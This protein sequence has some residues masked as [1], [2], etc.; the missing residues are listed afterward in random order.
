M[1][2]RSSVHFFFPFPSLV[3]SAAFKK[4]EACVVLID[5]FDFP[6]PSSLLIALVRAERE[7]GRIPSFFP[8]P[9]RATLGDRGV[10]IRPP[11]RFFLS[12]PLPSSIA[13][14]GIRQTS[15]RIPPFPFGTVQI[16]SKLCETGSS[17][18]SPPGVVLSHGRLLRWSFLSH[19]RR[20]R[21]LF[22]RSAPSNLFLPPCLKPLA[23][24]MTKKGICVH[25]KRP[26]PP[27]LL[28]RHRCADLRGKAEKKEAPFSFFSC[29]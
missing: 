8:P 11:C 25:M 17:L 23:D 10:A 24:L 16:V 9:P 29:C 21:T 13:L 28:P 5:E 26:P 3:F 7:S 6:P 4:G 20:A 1:S 27:L 14:R 19:G 18:S 22:P 15:S 12:P 2:N